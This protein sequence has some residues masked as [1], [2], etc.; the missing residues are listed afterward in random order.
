MN[1][2]AERRLE[3][4]EARRK[5][6]VDAAEEVYAD[7]GWDELTID[8]VA[9]KARLSRALVYVYFKDKFDLHCAICERALLLLGDRFEQAATRH[10][11]GRDQ[12]EALGRAYVA[13]SQEVPH[14]FQAL[15]RFEAHSPT[16]V[17]EE[18]N[19]AACMVAGDR[20]HS[21]MVACIE[22]GMKDGSVRP[23]LG[24]PY[25]TSVTLWGFMHGIIQIAA[26]KAQMLAKD[27]I[28][29]QQMID[30]A[31]QMVG[32]GLAAKDEAVK[33]ET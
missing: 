31:L 28:S 17:D 23:D 32:F 29:T 5:Q 19:E 16:H 18:S 3:E 25:L 9:R 11:R 14:Y 15:A 30:H 24:N 27:G 6:I 10:S 22:N 2:I 7:T 21:I 4:K 33:R 26:T 20:V 1:Y 8:Q 12:V 13:F